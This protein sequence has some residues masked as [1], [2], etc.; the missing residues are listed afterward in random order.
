MFE[1]NHYVPIIRWKRGEQKALEYLEDSLKYTMTPLIEVPPIDWDF[2]NEE[3]KKTID[4][5]LEG[6]GD[7]IK[8]SWNH[9]GAIFIDAYHVCLEDIELM[10]N[11]QHPL[12][13]IIS[14]AHNK[15]ITAIPVT[16]IKRGRNYQNAV[17]QLVET[18]K[19][20]YCL[21]LEDDDFEDIEQSL[22]I[23]GETLDIDYN[24]VDLIIDY[25]YIDPKYESRIERLILGTIY[26]IPLLSSW[27][28]FTIC[29]TA[30]PKNLSDQISTGTDGDIRRSEW[31]IYKKIITKNLNRIPAFGD[32]IIT[33]PEYLEIDPRF[34]QMAANIRY[35]TE[36]D[37]L[38]LRGHSIRLKGWG[39]IVDISKRLVSNDQ[40]SGKD[41]SYGDH[42]IYK[43]SLG[44][45][46]TG[47]A[48]TWRRVGT[49]HHLTLIIN[50]LSNLHEVSTF[51]LS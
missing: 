33:H 15:G 4:E 47:N 32:Y 37:Y 38:I 11:G 25:K 8:K 44:D 19:N 9:N 6:I 51:H 45:E 20:G 10:S 40:Y 48:E 17:K 7:T 23:I 1:R 39:Q 18:Y 14:E 42:Y 34:M 27:R 35:T 30:F 13:Y 46:S 36:E 43:C 29:G 26:E 21:R 22:N 24:E 41:F 50:Q 2:Q 31:Q 12:E 49:N 3:P 5:H 28:T 16:G